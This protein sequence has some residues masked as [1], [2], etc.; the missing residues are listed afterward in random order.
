MRRGSTGSMSSR[1]DQTDA[2][3]GDH[4]DV[5]GA[6]PVEI[7][8]KEIDL[9]G[10]TNEML[11]NTL[12]VTVIQARNLQTAALRSTLSSYVK[13]SSL[14]REYKTSVVSKNDE[15]YWN[16]T[17]S[18][19]AVDWAASVTLSVRD[20]IN[21]KMRFLGQV[22]ISCTDVAAL[23]GMAT[24]SWFRLRDKNW[25]RKPGM[26]SELE[27]KVALVYTKRNDPT[28]M[29]D[30][31]KNP[32]GVDMDDDAV[33]IVADQDDETED[34]ALARK[35]ELERLESER[36]NTLYANLRQGDYQ[37]QLH[38]IEARDLKGENVRMQDALE[39]ILPVTDY[40]GYAAEW[41]VGS[42][43]PCRSH[44]P[45]EKDLD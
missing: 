27:L 38:V 8:P 17:F 14:G 15:P 10:D 34:E 6:A 32:A 36:K 25:E 23:P 39:C 24:Q 41:H 37:V 28:I 40:S 21:V 4:D 22:R 33:G 35:S 2:A 5:F 9:A 29:R 20:K 44:G 7:L 1:R 19:R 45:E 31:V 18:F 16:E 11:P 13:V 12:V 3:D 26:D 30:F 43:R 42:V